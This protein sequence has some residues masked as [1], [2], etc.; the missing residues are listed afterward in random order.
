MLRSHWYDGSGWLMAEHLYSFVKDKHK[1]MI[2]NA[3]FL[4]LTADESIS[5]DNTS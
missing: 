4:A 5:V 2:E 3:S 1:S